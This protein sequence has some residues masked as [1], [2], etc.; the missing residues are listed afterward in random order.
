MAT[1]SELLKEKQSLPIGNVYQKTIYGKTY[2]YYQY[3][4]DGKRFTE[5][6]DNKTAEE[7]KKQVARRKEIERLIKDIKSKEKTIFLSKN[8]LSYT[9]EVMS[10][11]IP[12][13]KFENGGLV[14]IN[15]ELAPLVI[16]RTH[17]LVAFL[18]LRVIDMSRTNARILKR[19]LGINVEEDEVLSLYSYALSVGDNYWFK[20]K[21]SKYKYQ[22]VR[23]Q[24]DSLFDLALKGNSLYFAMKAKLSPELTTTGSFEKG[25]KIIDNEWWLYK[26]GSSKQIFSELFAYLFAELIGVNTALYQYD[27]GY[28]RSKNF[29]RDVNFEP[30][31]ALLGDNDSYQYVFDNLIKINKD[32]AKDYLK[33]MMFDAVIYNVDRHNENT[34]LLRDRNS[35][36]ILSLAPNFDNNLALISTIDILNEPKKDGLIKLFIEF[37]KNNESAL[38]LYKSI[39][40]KDIDKDAINGIIR[41][42]PIEMDNSQDIID[43]I[44]QRYNYLK[45]IS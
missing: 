2:T 30:L 40:F 7:L 43:K 39:P 17:S 14:S 26:S 11:D 6:V 12:V 29:A 21:H 22:D 34:G 9:G 36:A 20:P 28:I 15:E 27:D 35:G 25:W 42:I 18:K 32:I 16:K 33:L 45:N 24:D 8:S 38:A 5:I 23:F 31:A 4:K 19:S 13:A 1:L 41:L 44:Y 10:G 37:L 3:F